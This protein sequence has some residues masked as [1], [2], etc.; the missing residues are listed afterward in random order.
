MTPSGRVFGQDSLEKSCHCRT[1]GVSHS[2]GIVSDA[3]PVVV[4]ALGEGYFL[5]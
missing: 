5:A 1:T 2:I 3:V 4:Y